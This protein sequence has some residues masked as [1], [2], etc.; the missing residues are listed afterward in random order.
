[1]L[2]VII[3]LWKIKYVS[4]SKACEKKLMSFFYSLLKGGILIR[5][6]KSIEA[7]QA[8]TRSARYSRISKI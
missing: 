5:S 8:Y 3:V 1:M 4:T 7:Y 2:H 6:K